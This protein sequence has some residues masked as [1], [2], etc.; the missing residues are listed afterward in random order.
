MTFSEEQ[1]AAL[2][3]WMSEQFGRDVEVTACRRVAT[4]HSRA[5]VRVETNSGAFMV[6]M[7]QGGVFGTS[8]VE[9]YGVMAALGRAGYPVATVRGAEESGRV[10]GRPFFLMDW[11]DVPPPPGG[12]ERAMDEDAAASFIEALARLHSLDTT[13]L[14]GAFG[15]LP[16]TP[17]EA[18]HLQIDRWA[19]LYRRSVGETVPLLEEGAAWLHHFAPPLERL[20][21]VHGDAGPG[22]VL[23][24]DGRTLAVT[25]WEFS[26]LGDPA[27]DWS[28]TLAIR[29]RR[30]RSADEWKGLFER[31]S[32]F[33]MTD[34]G[35]LYW[36]AFNLFKGACANTSTLA[37]FEAGT[38]RS[39][40]MA[41]IGTHLHQ[42]FLRR[43]ASI[44]AESLP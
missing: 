13:L 4:G 12:D 41:I 34:A 31:H 11:I 2:A 10:L 23:F 24:R 1:T 21:I 44:T 14:T 39:P 15:D 28:F 18:V 7:E 29:G 19:A 5:M 22:N 26:H 33:T 37:L 16:S 32:G 20:S 9:E 40:N 3:A 27:E 6:R 35:W 42:T 43:L 17:S 36:E 25:D 38:N 8:G 30:T